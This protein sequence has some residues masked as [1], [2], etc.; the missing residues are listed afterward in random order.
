MQS[1][2][3][4]KKLK[5]GWTAQKKMK[6]LFLWIAAVHIKVVSRK[7]F[8]N[9]ACVGLLFPFLQLVGEKL[10]FPRNSPAWIIRRG[11][12]LLGEWEE[13]LAAHIA[14]NSTHTLIHLKHALV[15][16]AESIFLSKHSFGP[17]NA[18]CC[19][20]S[21]HIL[22]QSLP[23]VILTKQGGRYKCLQEGGSWWQW[24]GYHNTRQGGEEEIVTNI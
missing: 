13:H 10:L 7:L 3:A 8:C 15:N 24:K 20:V 23:D 11:H 6:K 5:R 2:F 9:N 19:A 12:L 16:I 21:H 14:D 1:N 4:N 18:Y 17:P 22:R